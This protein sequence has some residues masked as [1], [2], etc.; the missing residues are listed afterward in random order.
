M[1]PAEVVNP[2]EP[3]EKHKW[4]DVSGWTRSVEDRMPSLDQ[5]LDRYFDQYMESI[6][7]EWDLLTDVD[8]AKLEGR[9]KKISI[10]LTQLEKGHS[11]L[12]ERA[13][14]LDASLKGLEGR[15]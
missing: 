12:A 10:E 8:L 9:L 2:L 1:Y 14:A 15:R 4:Y 7:E 3:V 6:I 11:A 13:Q 5:S